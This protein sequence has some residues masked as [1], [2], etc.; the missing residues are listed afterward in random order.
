MQLESSLRKALDR[1]EFVL[2]Y[3]PRVD[4]KTGVI[5]G[6][7]A[8]VRW[9]H[10]QLGLIPPAA[11][12]PLAEETGLIEPIGQWVM[13]TACAQ[14]KKWQ[15]CGFDPISVAVNVS[16][17]QLAHD[18]LTD[19]VAQI[20]NETGLAPEYLDLELTESV[21][22]HSID[23]AIGILRRFKEMGVR[24]S[25]DDFGTGYSSLTYLK[26]F[27][28]DAVKIDQSF[29]R[30]LTTNSDDAAI[31]RA[32]IAMS[33]SL[34]LKVIAEG[35]ETIEQLQVLRSMDCDEIQ[36]YFVSRPVPA[37]ELES[38]MRDPAYLL[39]GDYIPKVA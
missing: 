8:L 3:Q 5:L 31:A 37:E 2:H 22:M 38:I 1:E 28:I 30:D 7:E 10:P 12:I 20:L 17:R 21:L 39:D 14:N 15:M 9:H 34:K 4:V 16:A 35:V 32:V 29:I 36:G 26:R 25:I 19:D 27:P 33:Q 23:L 13:R 6:V 11:F 18:G 24:L